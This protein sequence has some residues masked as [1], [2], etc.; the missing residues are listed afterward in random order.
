M[1]IPDQDLIF[2]PIPDPGVK[3]AP[4][5][6]S[7][8][9]TLSCQFRFS[10]FH[11]SFDKEIHIIFST[12]SRSRRRC[13]CRSRSTCWART[14]CRQTWSRRRRCS[15][16]TRPP[17]H[18]ND[19]VNGV[20]QS[21]ELLIQEEHFAADKK[22]IRWNHPCHPGHLHLKGTQAWNFFSDFFCRNRNHMVPRA[23]NTRFLK[24][25]FELAEIFDF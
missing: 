17:H 5:P 16:G 9:A 22:V 7:G 25:V 20:L 18:P 23:C 4:D 21:S 24:I 19:K 2:L 13:W 11:T 14:R 3:K 10:F 12:G 6:G 1:F 8:S 15:S